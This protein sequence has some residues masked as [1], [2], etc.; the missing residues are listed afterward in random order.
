M[1]FLTRKIWFPDVSEASPEGL[2]AMG[3][4]LS[5]ERL[6]AAYRSG[7]FPWYSEGEPILW[8]SPDPRMV[9]FP[10]ELK[11]SKSLSKTIKSGKFRVT[12]NTQFEEVVKRCARTPRKDQ[13]GTWITEEMREAY[14]ELHQK[15]HAVSV[16]V[17]L[18]EELVGGLY[19]VDL[20][21]LKI[22]CGESMFSKVSDASKVGFC[23]LISELQKKEYRLIDCQIY[24]EHLERLGAREIPREAF[25]DFLKP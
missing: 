11:I 4:D 1:Q 19:G 12:M 15:G 25:L 10:Q 13:S 16:E 2:L 18:E 9:L 5:V 8:W 14:A 20:P 7:I 21:E 3:G 22:F 23:H 6:L 24:T 17:W